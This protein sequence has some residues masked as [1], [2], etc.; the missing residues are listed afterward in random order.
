MSG[1]SSGSSRWHDAATV[2][3][4]LAIL[5]V[6]GLGCSEPPRPQHVLYVDT[7][8][9]IAA[10]GL[11]DP[12]IS[13]AALI[14]TL[15]VTVLDDELRP[16]DDFDRIFVLPEREEWPLSFG[17]VLD[18]GPL[19]LRLRAY[20]GSVL[21]GLD[22]ALHETMLASLAIERLV[23][24]ATP[25]DGVVHQRVV[26]SLACMGKPSDAVSRATCIDA[27]TPSGLATEGIEP[28][29]EQAQR[30]LRATPSPLARRQPCLGAPPPGAV[31]I[32]G[33]LSILGD[34]TGIGFEG[35]EFQFAPA[36]PVKPVW[37]S[38]FWLDVTEIT[39]GRFRSLWDAGL[40]AAAEPV[41]GPGCTWTAADPNLP[42]TCVPYSSARAACQALQGDLSSEAQWNHAARGL[43]SSPYPW[44]TSFPSCC[45]VSAAHGGPT[46]ACGASG[47]Q[48]VASHADPAACGGIADVTPEGVVD[49]GGSATE[50]QLDSP[51]AYDHPC[52]GVGLERDPVC[53]SGHRFG[54]ARGGNF[55]FSLLWVAA[56]LRH[57]VPLDDPAL[58]DD[59]FYLGFRCAYPDRP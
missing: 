6:A 19:L 27:D 37:L 20:R 9:A 49:L 7:D 26:L 21:D 14:D 42:L 15:E 56:L 41:T 11:G 34:P 50:I 59:S 51:E 4:L 52:W 55:S 58:L 30:L 54:V 25:D 36:F 39:V 3:P 46:P 12:S 23:E 35:E 2:R 40:V 29:D 31:C 8:A 18:D 43:G 10:E 13:P 53:L 16:R 17:V 45:G 32:P 57:T 5:I 24:L 28:T 38:P 33:G 22:E 1:I 48:P 44:G 47:I